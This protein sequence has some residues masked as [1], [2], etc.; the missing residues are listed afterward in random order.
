[1]FQN[2]VSNALKPFWTCIKKSVSIVDE[3]FPYRL[4][5]GAGS[6]PPPGSTYVIERF[7][8]WSDGIE[9]VA[10]R[11]IFFHAELNGLFSTCTAATAA[12][13]VS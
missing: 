5:L 10:E 11:G 2:W 7:S 6:V 3:G 9:R 8:N 13:A 12:H 4:L 1:M